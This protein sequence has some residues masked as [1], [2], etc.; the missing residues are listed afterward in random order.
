VRSEPP[1]GD[2]TLS[3]RLAGARAIAEVA[4]AKPKRAKEFAEILRAK[5]KI[6]RLK[7]V[8]FPTRGSTHSRAVRGPLSSRAHRVLEKPGSVAIYAFSKLAA[9]PSI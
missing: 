2:D 9:P 4:W 8:R 6:D 7:P 1:L 5:A 3:A